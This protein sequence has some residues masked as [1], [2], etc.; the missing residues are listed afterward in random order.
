M[1]VLVEAT[2]R[3]RGVVERRIASLPAQIMAVAL[4]P[5][6]ERILY[7]VGH[8]PP[9][10]WAATIGNGRL[11][12]RHRLFTDTAKFEFDQAAW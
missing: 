12:G 2:L 1:G 6:G 3:G 9:A 7:L 11:T 5:D 8:T 4:A 10:L